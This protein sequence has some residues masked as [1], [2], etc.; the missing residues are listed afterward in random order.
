MTKRSYKADAAAVH[1]LSK[2]PLSLLG[3]SLGPKN[4]RTRG[5]GEGI[6]SALPAERSPMAETFF[7]I[8]LKDPEPVK[9][10]VEIREALNSKKQHTGSARSAYLLATERQTTARGGVHI[11]D[12]PQP[13]GWDQTARN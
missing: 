5:H 4:K 3:T 12:H 2:G 13:D 11:R 8:T 7:E 10:R 1:R 9:E 6:G